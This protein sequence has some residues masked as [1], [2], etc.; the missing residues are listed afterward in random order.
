MGYRGRLGP[1]G[2]D[3]DRSPGPSFSNYPPAEDPVPSRGTPGPPSSNQ[4]GDQLFQRT[5]VLL[6]SSCPSPAV[7]GREPPPLSRS[8]EAFSK[9]LPV[10]GTHPSEGLFTGGPHPES[11]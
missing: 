9:V 2:C 1:S 5:L 4:T 6:S 11:S 3:G 8:V 7:S 10:S